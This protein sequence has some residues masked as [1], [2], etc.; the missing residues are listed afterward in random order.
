MNSFCM[1]SDMYAEY[2]AG[3]IQGQWYVSGS[4]KE[5]NLTFA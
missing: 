4:G 1:N 5:A 2:H 3:E